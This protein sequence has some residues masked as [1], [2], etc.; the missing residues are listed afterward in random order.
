MQGQALQDLY[1]I[2]LYVCFELLSRRKG[3]KK[4]RKRRK[5]NK[6]VSLGFKLVS[7]KGKGVVGFDPRRLAQK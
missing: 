2:N 1:Q 3:K 7:L 4:E 5:A 6:S